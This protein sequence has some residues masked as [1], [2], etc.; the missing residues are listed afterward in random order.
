M[1]FTDLVD[2]QQ[3]D[4]VRREYTI[5]LGYIAQ[6]TLDTIVR[7]VLVAGGSAYYAGGET[8]L[9]GVSGETTSSARPKITLLYL[10]K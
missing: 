9:A 4:D 3:L 1:Y 8:T 2:L 5:E 7:N 6:E 10:Y